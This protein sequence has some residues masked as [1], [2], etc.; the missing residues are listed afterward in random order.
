MLGDYSFILGRFSLPLI[1]T[2]PVGEGIDQLL[3]LLLQRTH[4]K[5][6]VCPYCVKTQNDNKPPPYNIFKLVRFCLD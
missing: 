3:L 2:Q 4:S 5:L 6:V 1:T